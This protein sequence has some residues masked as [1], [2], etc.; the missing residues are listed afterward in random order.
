[1]VG[2]LAPAS[3]LLASLPIV[4]FAGIMTTF[5]IQL[6]LD[7]KAGLV[8]RVIISLG[9]AIAL[10]GIASVVFGVFAHAAG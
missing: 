6:A 3:M 7:Q 1:M 9:G 4:L 5:V 2:A 10:L 8:L